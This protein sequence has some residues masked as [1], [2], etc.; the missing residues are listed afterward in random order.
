M[1]TT[2]LPHS[3]E[4]AL[5]EPRLSLTKRVLSLVKEQ[6]LYL[7]LLFLLSFVFV[8]IMDYHKNHGDLPLYWRLIASLASVFTCMLLFQLF[9]MFKWAG[10][11]LLPLVLLFCVG[12]YAAAKNY[13]LE[14]S[15]DVIASIMETNVNEAMGFVN[16]A[17]V[18]YFLL[19]LLL[20]IGAIYAVNRFFPQKV[21]KS[22]RIL[23]LI[24]LFLCASALVNTASYFA[25]NPD[26]SESEESKK[27]YLEACLWPISD[28][29]GIYSK[30][31]QYVRR[32]G[33]AMSQLKKLPSCAD[34]PSEFS[35][36]KERIVIFHIGESLRA[37]RVP[38]NGYGR[39]TMPNMSKEPNVISIPRML[40]YGTVTRSS[41]IGMLSDADLSTK[42][43]RHSSYIDLFNKHQYSTNAVLTV[44][45]SI[46][47]YS[48]NIL[49]AHCRNRVDPSD[50]GNRTDNFIDAF[51]QE[52]SRQTNPNQLFILYNMGNHVPF[53]STE[54]FKKFLPDDFS[55]HKPLARLENMLNAYDNATVEYD[56]LIHRVISELKDKSAVYV[57]CA[58]H[59]ISLGEYGMFGQGTEVW[60]VRTP[61][62][63]I[64]YS[65]KFA[66]ENPELIARLKENKG[67]QVS[68]EYLF[69][70]MLSLGGIKS[71]LVPPQRDLTSP[72]CVPYT[73]PRQEW[74]EYE[75]Q[76]KNKGL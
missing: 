39:N 24:F 34:F 23:G 40:S 7:S 57:F 18:L 70:T 46:H 55:I 51:K 76:L 25:L 63:F 14:L 35:R 44:E 12:V 42:T 60:F 29:R 62:C 3:P 6:R 72:E 38:M 1:T 47:D 58:D 53:P 28:M 36:D 74:P 37:D 15:Y 31:R 5:H 50:K 27:N 20:G 67:K 56:D 9:R 65:D 61:A 4:P 13:C 10:Y 32:E 48:M 16:T 59:G 17:V 2:D 8:W 33:A 64:W 66:E 19:F 45:N 43:P 69:G 73:G 21:G 30:I 54:K 71:S 75:Q 26:F 68:H 11:V 41:V 22:F 49:T 52:L